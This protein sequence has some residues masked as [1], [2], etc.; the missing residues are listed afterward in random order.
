M[1]EQKRGT[2]STLSPPS[3][4]GR[5]VRA[6][7]KK[8][9]GGSLNLSPYAALDRDN[10][11]I[12]ILVL[13]P[14][15]GEEP[16]RA[17]LEKYPLDDC[18]AFEAL[19]YAWGDPKGVEPIFIDRSSVMVA[20]NL[21]VAL[22]NIRHAQSRR[23]LWIDAICIDQFNTG[24][25]NHQVFLMNRVYSVADKVLIWL[26]EARIESDLA[27][28]R[29]YELAQGKAIRHSEKKSLRTLI[30]DGLIDREWWSRLWIVQEVVLARS[31]P[32]L[33]CGSRCLDWETYNRAFFPCEWISMGWERLPHILNMLALFVLRSRLSRHRAK[34]HDCAGESEGL[35]AILNH[36]KDFRTNDPRDKI[37]GCLGLLP[38]AQRE[39]IRP[40]YQKPIGLL[41]HEVAQFLIEHDPHRFFSAFSFTRTTR[42]P[43]PSWVPDF[44][45]QDMMGPYNPQG[46][47][48][49]NNTGC[50]H[51]QRSVSFHDDNRALAVKGIFID[52]I[53]I[54]VELQSSKDRL[55]SQIPKLESIAQHANQKRVP[56]SHPRHYLQKFRKTE[57]ILDV[58]YGGRRE[59]AFLRRAY[60]VLSGKA[61]SDCSTPASCEDYEL[62]LFYFF[63]HSL[64]G[65]YFFV[66]SLGFAGITVGRIRPNDVVTI[67]FGE[68]LPIILRPQG[69]SF[70]MIGAAYVSGITKGEVT[71]E[72][73]D[74]GIM[75]ET[76]FVLR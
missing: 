27:I 23:V 67:L 54:A 76:T 31:D 34:L 37:Y 55:I 68:R 75:E 3:V 44:A 32:V 64:G 60:N 58:L 15:A 66:T 14:G 49:H 18:P 7:G 72:M 16:L 65:R 26:G 20:Q 22:R 48:Y 42:I 30:Y 21:R 13:H 52:A 10:N 9:D 25:R 17:D 40:E 56:S 38:K 43:C 29:L 61:K 5:S 47:I 24:E 45:H 6:G 71:P 28:D 69:A 53:A 11:E 50:L 74:S 59:T 1:A 70:K 35:G 63:T 41:Y 62:D 33:M 39:A 8:R 57:D 46:M 36:T 12:R 2:H 73:Y 51:D 19:S 4:E